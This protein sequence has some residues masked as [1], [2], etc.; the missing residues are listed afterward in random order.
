MALFVRAQQHIHP[1]REQIG[2]LREGRVVDSA[3]IAI[4]AV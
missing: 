1:R 2:I 3:L 4:E